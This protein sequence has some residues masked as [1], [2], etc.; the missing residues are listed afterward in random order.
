MLSE[1]EQRLLEK[2]GVAMPSHL[3]LTKVSACAAGHSRAAEAK[4]VR[5][6]AG[7]WLRPS[8]SSSWGQSMWRKACAWTWLGLSCNVRLDWTGGGKHS[9]SVVVAAAA[10]AMWFLFVSLGGLGDIETGPGLGPVRCCRLGA[11]QAA[12]QL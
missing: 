8:R 10:Q 3:P 2:E 6:W 7:R 9:G 4:A 11:K 5:A 1:E 12:A